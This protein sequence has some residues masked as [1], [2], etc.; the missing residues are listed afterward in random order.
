M[1]FTVTSSVTV[2]P[3]SAVAEVTANEVVLLAFTENANV[4]IIINDN[5]SAKIVFFI[6]TS[7]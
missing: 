7:P 3:R 1:L 6:T 4:K 5:A 2:A